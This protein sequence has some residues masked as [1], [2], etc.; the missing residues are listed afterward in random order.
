MHLI[1]VKILENENN[2][3][4]KVLFLVRNIILSNQ[5]NTLP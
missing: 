1:E 3:I 5:V 4:K 2:N